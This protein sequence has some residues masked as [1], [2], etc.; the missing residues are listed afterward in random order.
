MN[1]NFKKI[2][3]GAISVLALQPGC[4]SVT[5][6]EQTPK[7]KASPRY[8]PSRV[9][10]GKPGA[11]LTVY[12]YV[13]LGSVL[14]AADSEAFKSMIQK[15]P[16][17]VNIIVKHVPLPQFYPSSLI[18]S[19]IFE[20][21]R[22]IDQNRAKEFYELTLSTEQMQRLKSE[23]DYWKMLKPLK[24]PISQIKQEIAKGHG[25]F[26]ILDDY[27]EYKSLGIEGTPAYVINGDVLA[28]TRPY[29]ELEQ[30]IEKHLRDAK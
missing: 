16:D 5:K 19:Q 13:N 15:Y 8:E 6:I 22:E 12:R 14:Q 24:F 25:T 28:G 29:E 27:A 18:G 9:L 20:A 17:S 10:Y 30:L 4:S 3:I 7:P 1:A 11:P 21:L 26:R 23:D 2:F